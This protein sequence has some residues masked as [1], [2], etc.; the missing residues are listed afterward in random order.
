MSGRSRST[1]TSRSERRTTR[2]YGRSTPP[3]SRRAT[4]T[5]AAPAS[6]PPTTR[7]TTAPSSWTPTGTTSRSSTTTAE[8]RPTPPPDHHSEYL[9]RAVAALT[10]HGRERVDELLDQLAN[11]AGNRDDIVRFAKAEKADA[12]LGRTST[13]TGLLRT[14]TKRELDVLATGFTTDGQ[15]P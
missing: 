5:T 8:P 13:D 1:F 6:A 7:A 15:L 11:A 4:R 14:L 9:A 2:Q 3:R 12:D 10:S